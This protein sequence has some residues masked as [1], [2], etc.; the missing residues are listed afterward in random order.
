MPSQKN[1]DQMEIIKAK[2]EKS[3]SL[4]VADYSGL[5]SAEQTELRAKAKSVGG[6]FTVTKNRLTAIALKE[7][8]VDAPEAL[9]KALEGPNAII[10]SF[11]D[12]V[13]AVKVVT[14]FAKDHE[15]LKVKLG[16]LIGENGQPDQVLD[17]VRV[18]ALA[19]LPSKPELISNLIG[20]LN[21]P[22]Y[23]LVSV[24]SGTTRKLVYVL[25]AI[26]DQK[27]N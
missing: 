1:L 25:S 19:S 27:T 23:G 8:T 26:R 4:I 5:N 22:I 21:A 12:P 7:H 9:K 16:L 15:S 20:Q 24:L 2:L 13:A 18:K 10:Y 14:Q 11:D 6:E 3:Q 17:T